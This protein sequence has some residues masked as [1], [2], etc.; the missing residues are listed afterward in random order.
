[1]SHGVVVVRWADRADWLHVRNNRQGPREGETEAP[2]ELSVG[3][4]IVQVQ[5]SEQCDV[6]GRSRVLL[7]R[8]GGH[9]G[10]S[11]SSSGLQK[12]PGRES[13]RAVAVCVGVFGAKVWN[14]RHGLSSAAG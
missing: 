13:W 12:A 10:P 2:E 1:M 9:G 5:S 8:A 14:V 7:F 3:E 6:A 11:R 4:C